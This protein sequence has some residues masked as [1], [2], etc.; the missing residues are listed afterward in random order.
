MKYIF[1]DNL[2][3]RF[4]AFSFSEE[5]KKRISFLPSAQITAAL[6]NEKDAIGLIPTLDL[7]THEQLFVSKLGGV[8]FESEFCNSYLYFP[9]NIDQKKVTEV[10]LSGDVSSL[11]AILC[12]ILFA[13]LYDQQVK[14]S[15]QTS[16]EIESDMPLLLVGDTNFVNERCLTGI[17]FADGAIEILSAP[18]VNFVFAGKEK[19]T[20]IA[21]NNNFAS[22]I[23][24]LYKSILPFIASLNLTSE[25]KDKIREEFSSFVFEFDSM[26]IDGIAQ[27]TRLPYYHVMIKEMIE[28]KFV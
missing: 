8:S 15:L 22:L 23:P 17:S 28:I 7:L 19:E 6:L 18:F 5:E 11:E 13:E 14:M 12:K 27:L 3:S 1:P 2:F 20:V 21:F 9:T 4:Y 24:M 26:D 10:A 16:S 25:L